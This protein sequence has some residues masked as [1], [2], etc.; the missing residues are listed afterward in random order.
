MNKRVLAFLLALVL[1]ATL[2]ISAAAEE[3]ERSG[4]VVIL[5][6]GD[7]H[8]GVDEGFGYA[9]LQEIREY[10]IACGDDV[11]LV[12]V[13]DNIQGGPIGTV[14]KG[15]LPLDLMNAMGY[16]VAVPG[17]HEFDY[18]MEQFLALAEK[19]D[20]PYV[21]CNFVKGD[22][23]VFAPYVIKAAGSTKIAFVG[24]CTPQTLTSST[25]K[26]FQDEDGN[27]IYGFL[28]DG[29]GELLYSAVQ[30]AVDDARAEGAEYVILLA[31][32]GYYAESSPYNYA[33]VL[34]H[35][36]G[37]DAMLDG[38][39][40]DSE[41]VVMKDKNNH[42]VLRSASGTKLENV[43]WC[44][45]TADGEVSAGLYSWNNDVRAPDL[46]G[47]E[48][49]MS[50]AVAGAM[51]DLSK[52]LDAVVFQTPFDLTISDPE[53]RDSTGSPV[54][55]VRRAETN[56]GDLAADAYRDQAGTD[57]AFIIG[58]TLRASIPAGDVTMND[59]LRVFPFGNDMAA[60]E[61]TGQQ[62]LD[63]LEWGS[64]SVPGEN[65]G[66]LQ[67]S[68]L[69]YEIHTYIESSCIADENGYFAGVEGERRVKNV[70][71]GGEPIDPKATYSLA[72]LDYTLLD[73]GDGYCM[74]DGAKVLQD[75]VKADIRVLI[76]YIAETLGGMPGEEYEDPYGTGRIVI[77]EV[78]P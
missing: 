50:G 54:R 66:F 43:G 67:V 26:Y 9:G 72:G 58:G 48:N 37:V 46:L 53:A 2:G 19:A 12:D 71:V 18:G 32:L 70:L 8:C 28:Q 77:V 57:I 27:F 20:F 55:M 56:L 69:S 34:S 61:V 41:Q 5:Y 74:F 17:N 73:Q 30:N 16:D 52:E 64:R 7:V 45:I 63:A 38:H 14:T 36:S 51:E 75:R 21:S 60:I 49:D 59:V 25:P 11:I 22:E 1:L 44:R 23:L 3:A 13:G 15:E 47:L 65:G 31:H 42:D 35:V 4:D 62:I 68:G 6:T 40:H 39:S 33:D 24:V 10:L 29:S 76:D 78:A